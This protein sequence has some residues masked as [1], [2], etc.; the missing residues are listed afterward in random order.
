M[1]MPSA[2]HLRLRSPKTVGGIVEQQQCHT[3]IMP[4]RMEEKG[5]VIITKEKRV[6]IEALVCRIM[7]NGNLHIFLGFKVKNLIVRK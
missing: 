4:R 5:N 7:I 6:E 1:E 2:M 3:L